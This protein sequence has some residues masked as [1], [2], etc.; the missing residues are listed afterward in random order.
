MSPA[1]RLAEFLVVGGVTP[2]LFLASW[3]MRRTLDLD[4]AE[5]ATGFTF[6]Y[7][8]HLLNDPHFS[9][10][11]LLFYE[12]WRARAFGER[13]GRVQRVRYWLAGVAV[14][15]ALGIWALAALRAQ[16]SA[17]L[18]AMFQLMFLLVGW[19]YVKQGFGV[20]MVLSAR[21]GVRF[22]VVE[23]RVI[24][25]HCYT[26]WFYAWASPFDPGRHLVEKGVVYSTFAHPPLLEPI[27]LA[28]LVVSTVALVAVL[29]RKRRREG[30]LPLLTPLTGLLCSVWAWSIFSGADPLVRYAIPALH[31]LQYLYFVRL[32]KVPQAREREGPPYF[33]TSARNR[34]GL[35]VISALAL[36]LFFFDLA[37][38]GLDAWLVPSGGYSNPDMGATPYFAALFTVVNLH[39]YGMDAVIWRRDNPM[40]R[41]LAREQSP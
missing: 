15:L 27:T 38:M 2:L 16:S 39:H 19:H 6:Y 11:Y 40:T 5:Y 8:A 13:F 33:E 25:A 32:L 41:Y 17:S 4:D 26:G 10:T 30:P 29:V 9:V 14:P 18:G 7:A 35:L 28:A 31:S 12:D 22:D 21:R 23:R 1:R 20:M 37:P 34:I 24:L 36:G 3:V